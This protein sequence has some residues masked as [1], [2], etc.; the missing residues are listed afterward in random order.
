[1][2]LFFFPSQRRL[3]FLR[4]HRCLI[5]SIRGFFFSAVENRV[6]KELWLQDER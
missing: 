3:S 6:E 2:M 5:W 1:M 4:R